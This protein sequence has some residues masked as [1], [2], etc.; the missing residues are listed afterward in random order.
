MNTRRA[1]L[2]SAALLAGGVQ[3]QSAMPAEVAAE[4]P[5]ARLQGAGR[6]RFLGLP[7]YDA[8]LWSGLQKVDGNNANTP[9]ALEIQY[10][11]ALPGAQI[12]ERS[13]AEMRR[14]S[15]LATDTAARWLMEMRNIFP[16]VQRGDRVTGVLQ[17]GRG[18]RFFINGGFK[19]EIQDAG[20]GPAF[21]GIWLSPQTSEPSLREALL[22][23]GAAR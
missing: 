23:A 2:A 9:L 5:A 7:V 3:A 10:L 12:A 14:Q 13:L 16:D 6:L 4:L 22:G 18:T 11:R 15:G 21:F 20:F 8:L 17:P 19:G 1:L